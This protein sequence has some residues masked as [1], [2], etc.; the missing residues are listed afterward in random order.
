MAAVAYDGYC[1]Q[2]GYKSLISGAALPPFDK[3]T[4]SIKDAWAAA[5][6]AILTRLELEE[7][8]KL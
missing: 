4:D 6:I 3:L 1:R 7:R 8:G 2:T 5:A